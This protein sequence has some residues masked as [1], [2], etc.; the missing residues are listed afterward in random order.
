MRLLFVLPYGPSKTRVR[1]RML[2]EVLAPRH[3]VTIVALAWGREDDDA[4]E[5]WRRRGCVVH[6]VPHP[7]WAWARNL[8]GDPRRPLQAIASA[9]PPLRALVARLLGE[10]QSEQRPFDALHV[11]H[12]RGA[13]ALGLRPN[14]GVRTIFDAVDCLAEL[15]QVTRRHNP[16]LLVRLLAQLEEGRTKR[17][18]SYFVASANATSVVAM[19]DREAL[20]SGGAPDQVAVIPNGVPYFERAE[21]LTCEPVAIFT[22]KLSYHANQAALRFLLDSIWPHVRKAMPL[23]RLVIAGANPPGWLADS[24]MRDGI[25]VVANPPEIMPLIAQSRVALAP[26]VYSVGIQNKVL[27]AMACGVPV[28]ATPSA[29]AGLLPAAEGCL[30]QVESAEMFAER[31][32]QLLTDDALTARLGAAGRDYAR[33]YHSW[34]RCATLFES[35]YVGAIPAWRVG[36]GPD[37]VKVA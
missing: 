17:L 27:E 5:D 34:E 33:T 28:V 11:E 30:F 16:R 3:D 18:E 9:S 8:L 22:G 19:R 1:S 32:V 37:V 20:I 23:A 24:A 25:A 35:L 31:T 13:A 29:T 6:A 21:P 7:R 15:A 14:M 36:I 26:I 4:L 2:L 12:L 10:A